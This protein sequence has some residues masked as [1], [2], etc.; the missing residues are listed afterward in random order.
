MTSF[1]CTACGTQYPD[2]A[3]PPA[4][5]VICTEE[6]QYVPLTGQGWTT[7]DRLK[8]DRQNA[9]RQYEPGVTGIGT[10]PAFGIGQR[11]I[12]IQTPHGN[13]LWDC[14]AFLDDATVAIIK[15][16]GGLKAIAI[17]HPHF[18]TTHGEW[19]R[20]FGCKVYMHAA[21]RKWVQRPSADIVHW[22]GDT[23]SLM[24]GVTLIRCG[25]HFPGGNVLHWAGGA[26][27]K[28]IVCAG[29]ILTVTVDHKWLSFMRSYPNFIPLS[30]REVVGIQRALAPFAFETVYGHYMDRVIASDAKAVLDASVT[31][32][33]A[34]INGTARAEGQ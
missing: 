2:S 8:I 20:A 6:R 7:L 4:H 31:R 19:T 28:G 1:L 11:A 16:L 27:G 24:P 17:S 13:V 23:H 26:G 3:T 10:Q 30:G 14:V 15:A 21:D 25:G 22:D 18:Y 9:F 34:N 29:D 33:I 5:C 12:L 32:Y